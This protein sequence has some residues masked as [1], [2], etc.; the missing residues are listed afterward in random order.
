MP[1]VMRT[2]ALVLL[3]IVSACGPRTLKPGEER[4][5]DKSGRKRG[6]VTAETPSFKDHDTWYFR[7]QAT[8]VADLTLGL[9]QA[10]ADAKK[11]IISRIAEQVASEYSEYALGANASEGDKSV[12]VS[13]GI[14]WATEGL[15][16]SGIAPA[17]T[18]WEK[19]E[20]GRSYGGTTS[21]TVYVLLG[22]PDTDY[23][24][25]RQRAA[26]AIE[27]RARA[28]ADRRA[29][30]AARRLRQTLESSAVE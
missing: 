26:R 11:R 9:R 29:A 1:K 27:A 19:I 10:E 15:A 17:K 14:S 8:G 2:A 7:G 5:V 16:V 3:L 4:T 25:A 28:A 13:D 12:F 18:Y 30:E 20:T 21:F 22:L 24:M 6:W 23:E